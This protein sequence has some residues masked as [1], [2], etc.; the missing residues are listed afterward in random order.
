[1]LVTCDPGEQ[2]VRM[3]ILLK[4]KTST[5]KERKEGRKQGWLL[6]FLEPWEIPVE[7]ITFHE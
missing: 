7:N 2:R 3:L 1:M 5:G 4:K 6:E